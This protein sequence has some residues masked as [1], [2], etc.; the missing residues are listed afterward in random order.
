MKDCHYGAIKIKD[1]SLGVT[2]GGA[3]VQTAAFGRPS[4][5][6]KKQPSRRCWHQS[7]AEYRI[8]P[9]VEPVEPG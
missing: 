2:I 1:R 5:M 6:R 7:S 8:K 3:R 4:R 9:E